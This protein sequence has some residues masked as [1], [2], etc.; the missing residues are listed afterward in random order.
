MSFRSVLVIYLTLESKPCHYA[1]NLNTVHGAQEFSR[2]LQGRIFASVDRAYGHM[3]DQ[4]NVAN[5]RYR[6]LDAGRLYFATL[7]YVAT[8]QNWFDLPRRSTR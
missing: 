5:H 4:H 2:L 1:I 3:H 6:Y 7:F 8:V